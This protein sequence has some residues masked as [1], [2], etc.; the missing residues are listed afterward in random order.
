MLEVG[1]MTHPSK[2]SELPSLNQFQTLALKAKG[3][4][5]CFVSPDQADEVYRFPTHVNDQGTQSSRV[6][7][8]YLDENGIIIAA[9]HLPGVAGYY[10]NYPDVVAED[11]KSEARH[12][13]ARKRVNRAMDILDGFGPNIFTIETA[14]GNEVLSAIW[15]HVADDRRDETLNRMREMLVYL[16]DDYKEYLMEWE[17]ERAENY[18]LDN[19]TLEEE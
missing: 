8:E 18:N 12:I 4:A 16:R 9:T 1:T 10:L 13:S 6:L 3:K 5:P 17:P 7:V 11:E 14:S 15:V 19:C 2:L